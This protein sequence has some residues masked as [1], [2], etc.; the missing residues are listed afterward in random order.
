MWKKEEHAVRNFKI[1]TLIALTIVTVIMLFSGC[2]SE[3]ET[4][5][6][7]IDDDFKNITIDV[8]T[9]DIIFLPSQDNMCKV[10]FYEKASKKH[11]SIVENEA[12]VI[13]YENEEKWYQNIFNFG[14][15]KITVYLPKNEYNN[16][17]IESTTGDIKL[18]NE[19]EFKSI[20]IDLTT[21]DI[22]LEKIQ[23]SE[24][25][26]SITTGDMELDNINCSGNITLDSTTG[27][28]ELNNVNCK[29]LKSTSTTGEIT[30]ESVIATEKI[31]IERSTG[32]VEFDRMDAGEI[33]IETSTGDV[34]GSLLSDK[35]FI[36]DTSTGKK[37]VPETTSGG[38][39]KITTSTGDIFINIE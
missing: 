25:N 36:V 8:D 9:E 10:V 27:E 37:R 32:D 39:C 3:Y 31:H 21:G 4:N 17:T 2:T 22:S 30:L 23:A 18:E 12:L 14:K 35:I 26:L 5:T 33:F 29:N 7:K 34:E 1:I 19:F 16:L 11:T 38:K 24:I 20:N 15:S 13:K 28:T 6:H